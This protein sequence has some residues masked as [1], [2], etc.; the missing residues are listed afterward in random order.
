MEPRLP[1]PSLGIP[2]YEK[3]AGPVFGHADLCV[4]SDIPIGRK[5]YGQTWFGWSLQILN[6][7]GT[8]TAEIDD[9]TISTFLP[10]LILTPIQDQTALTGETVV[11]NVVAVGDHSMRYQWQFNGTNL[12]GATHSTLTLANVTTSQ[13]GA[14]RVLVNNSLGSVLSAGA[15]LTVNP[16]PLVID[17]QPQ[18][19]T[20][21]YGS[22]DTLTVLAEG[23]GPLS[24]QWQFDGMNISGATNSSLVLS[25]FQFS[26]AGSYQVIIS[27]SFGSITSGV[28]T[29]SPPANT[30]ELSFSVSGSTLNLSW[31]TAASGFILESCAGLT[32]PTTW[33]AV[34]NV[35]NIDGPNNVAIVA[36][37]QWG[38]L[39]PAASLLGLEGCGKT[40]ID[41]DFH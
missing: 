19:Q 41:T 3:S 38:W 28:A 7:P 8:V 1:S 18:N 26:E 10:P 12:P 16:S 14:Y 20:V 33:N 36:D 31:P 37:G 6:Y 24:Y 9:A 27:N 22:N 23:A 32:P 2:G 35:P 17:S 5:K 21:G 4:S 25:Y 39:L 11:F 29:V 13:A 40:G 30:Y 34:T 15:T